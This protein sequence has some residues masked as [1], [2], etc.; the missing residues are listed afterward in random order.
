MEMETRCISPTQFQGQPWS[1]WTDKTGRLSPEVTEEDLAMKESSKQSSVMRLSKSDMGLFGLCFPRTSFTLVVCKQC[2]AVINKQGLR[3]HMDLRHSGPTV[4]DAR[5]PVIQPVI[6]PVAKKK[7][8]VKVMK[9]LLKNAKSKKPYPVILAEADS[10]TN[11]VLLAEADST[12]TKA[13]VNGDSVT[14]TNVAASAISEPSEETPVAATCPATPQLPPPSASPALPVHPPTP[15]P[16]VPTPP[17]PS[18]PQTVQPIL[19]QLKT[20]VANAATIQVAIQPTAYGDDGAEVP[21]VEVVTTPTPAVEPVIVPLQAKS[22]TFVTPAPQALQDKTAAPKSRQNL[23]KMKGKVFDVDKHCGVITEDM[24]HCTRSLTCRR[25]SA[26]LK[27]MIEGR[28]KSFDQLLADHKAA[29]DVLNKQKKTVEIVN[30]N[31]IPNSI[32]SNNVVTPNLQTALPIANENTNTTQAPPEAAIRLP[33]L[34]VNQTEKMVVIPETP[35]AA[36]QFVN[37][38]ASFINS[39]PEESEDSISNS[40]MTD[41]EIT[42]SRSAPK[43]LA[44]GLF[45]ALKLG[46]LYYPNRKLQMARQCLERLDN[47]ENLY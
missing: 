22:P 28:S 21:V 40:I 15:P 44:V 23:R 16:P 46:G 7:T 26:L 38:K 14:S 13:L 39:A 31:T 17:P 36:P 12:T 37:P 41:G 5:F 4:I 19:V 33:I 6:Q 1:A 20:G 18:A 32:H 24:K 2:S 34:I 42:Y 43:P 25:H 47:I 30:N 3:N 45:S 27:R 8:K 10:T 29:K 9:P 11:S 35:V